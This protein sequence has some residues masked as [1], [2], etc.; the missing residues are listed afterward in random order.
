M[1]KVK[2][3]LIIGVILFIGLFTGCDSLEESQNMTWSVDGTEVSNPFSTGGSGPPNE[4]PI[5][6][7]SDD[8]PPPPSGFVLFEDFEGSSHSF[9]IV[10]GSQTNKWFVGSASS[11][12]PPGSTRSAYISNTNGSTNNY[13]IGA[14]SVVHMFR[15]VTFPSSSSAFTLQ[16][17]WKLQGE[18][19]TMDWDYLRVFLVSTST[20]PSAGTQ[21]T[22]GQIGST[23]RTNNNTW[24]RASISIPA[25]NAGSTRRLVFTWRND[26]SVGSQPPVAIDNIAIFSGTT[27]PSTT[28]TVTYNL[29]NGNGTAPLTQT[30]NAGNSVILPSNVG[31]SRSGFTF[32]GWNTNASG[33]GT[34][35]TAGTSFIPTGNI[36]LFARWNTAGTVPAAP[37]NVTAVRNPAGSSNITVSWSSV[38]GATSYRVYYSSTGTDFGTQ[39]GGAITSTTYTSISKGTLQNHWFRVSAVN[40]NGEGEASSWVFVGPISTVTGSIIFSEDFE[41]SNSFTIVN[42]SQINQ[43]FVGTASS[44]QPLG[45][46]RSAYISNDNGST[47]FYNTGATSVV[48]M[49]R[50]VTFPTSSTPFTLEFDWKLQGE[51]ATMDY[52]YLRVF[53]VSNSTT[54]SAGTQLTSGQIGSTYRTS[55]NLWQRA[56]I[57][58]PASHSGSTMRLVFS[59][60]NDSSG[61]SQ[62]PVAIDNIVLYSG[63][64][65]LTQSNPSILVNVPGGATGRVPITV[66]SGSWGVTLYGE[67][68]TS[69][70]NSTDPALYDAAGAEIAFHNSNFNFIYF[71]PAGQTRTVFAGTGGDVASSYFITAAWD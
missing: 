45:S 11:A 15:N 3:L 41:G 8:L 39:E 60:R 67:C 30:V 49:H 56:T 9:T 22:S 27:P 59:W 65:T 53:L 69:T 63:G 64:I 42:G 5:E 54:P 28:Y 43:W 19:A 32:A 10:N 55:S 71:I 16:F 1:N 36:T 7:P 38:T 14:A 52:D 37:T 46:T 34:N 18:S 62:P 66:N 40:S 24:Q 25:S 4:P 68:I 2:L 13:N 23:Y 26:S 35:Y 21:L 33:T 12:Q 47:N 31:F 70:D 48:H 6:P 20:T 29:N 51:S 44:A 61:G 58:I 17:D 50:T 57:S